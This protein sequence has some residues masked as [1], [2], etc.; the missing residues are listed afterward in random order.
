MTDQQTIGQAAENQAFAHLLE[1]GL[2]LLERNYR[3][4][5]GEI[6][7]IMR[8]GD[9]TVFVEV[10]FRRNRRFG[11]AAESVEWRKQNKLVTTA[12]HY[13]QKHPQLAQHPARFDVVSIDGNELEWIKNAFQA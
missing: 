7:L 9:A 11:S 13:F 4:R 12:E 3:C 10:R 6:D 1:K 2:Q 8:D 5:R